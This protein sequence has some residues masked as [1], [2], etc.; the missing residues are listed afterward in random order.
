MATPTRSDDEGAKPGDAELP[1]AQARDEE[2]SR[3]PAG[4]KPRRVKTSGEQRPGTAG[5]TDLRGTDWQ[6][7]ST[8]KVAAASDD[9]TL[10]EKRAGEEQRSAGGQ[11][12]G[13]TRY[14]AGESSG[15]GIP[16]A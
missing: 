15:D 11:P 6:D 4:R 16:W 1:S 3:G 12:R 13:A 8:H 10:V 14:L 7:A 5:N 2:A 9:S